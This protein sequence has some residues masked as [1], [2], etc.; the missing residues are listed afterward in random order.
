MSLKYTKKKLYLFT[1]TINKLQIQTTCK[2]AELIE[3]GSLRRVYYIIQSYSNDIK[4]Y[5]N[6][7]IIKINYIH[8]FKLYYSNDIN[9]QD[10][11]TRL[12]SIN[13]NKSEC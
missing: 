8:E 9:I 5:N 1:F 7:E 13:F 2:I 6:Y 10:V 4:M 3:S 11:Q 12:I